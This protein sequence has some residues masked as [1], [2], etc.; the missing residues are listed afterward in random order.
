[1]PNPPPLPSSPETDL[2]AA[3]SNALGLPKR[4]LNNGCRRH[5]TCRRA[6]VPVQD[7]LFVESIGGTGLP[8][9]L[10]LVRDLL[11]PLIHELCREPEPTGKN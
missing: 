9:C 10:A 11:P 3:F 2:H 1:M 5:G 7:R 4:C 6:S 8:H